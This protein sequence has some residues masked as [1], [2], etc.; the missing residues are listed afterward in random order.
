MVETPT[1]KFIIVGDTGVGK[2]AILRR[3]VEN[4][5]SDIVHPTVGAEFESK[6]LTIGDRRM[7]LQIWDTAGQERFKSI[8]RSYYRNAVGVILVF[9]VTHRHSFRALDAWLSDVRATC[10]PNAV[11]Q[12]IGNKTDLRGQRDVSTDEAESFA[13]RNHMNYIET[14]AK[15]GDNINEA[16]IRAA[17]T[18]LK[19]GLADPG[20]DHR[21][22]PP[23]PKTSACC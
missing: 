21:A 13:Q 17:A 10:N 12:L 7:K 1:A 5:F 16:F 4:R 22:D 20:P 2:T 15:A 8:A 23:G 18:V 3:F 9:A 11:V 6:V 19:K 14:S